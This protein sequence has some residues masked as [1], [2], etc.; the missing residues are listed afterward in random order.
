M[1]MSIVTCAALFWALVRSGKEI[2]S[3]AAPKKLASATYLFIS[4]YTH[5]H[6]I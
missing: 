3:S 1:V 4:I 6:Y 2:A 5:K